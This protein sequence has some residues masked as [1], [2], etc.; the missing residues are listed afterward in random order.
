MNLLIK[1]LG[2][3]VK[4]PFSNVGTSWCLAIWSSPKW[5]KTH[6][7]KKIWELGFFFVNLVWCLAQK[8]KKSIMVQILFYSQSLTSLLE[9]KYE[10]IFKFFISCKML[11]Y[12]ISSWFSYEYLLFAKSYSNRIIGILKFGI[13]LGL[14]WLIERA[15]CSPSHLFNFWGRLRLKMGQHGS[16]IFLRKIT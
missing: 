15:L 12:G 7:T 16:P 11:N 4:V 14:A 6:A 9:K 8:K 13:G 1:I 5:V 2:K 10:V 3:S